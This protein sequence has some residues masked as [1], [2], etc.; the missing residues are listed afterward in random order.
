L[1]T[2]FSFDLKG[3]KRKEIKRALVRSKRRK[4]KENMRIYLR[5]MFFPIN[6]SQLVISSNF[7][8]C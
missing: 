3:E 2:T 4:S 5:N 8:V 7:N 6:Y 1:V